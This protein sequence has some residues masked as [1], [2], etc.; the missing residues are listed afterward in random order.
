MI[1][2]EK[3]KAGEIRQSVNYKYF[4]PNLVNTDWTWSDAKINR[5][6]E[7]ASFQLGQLNSFAKLVPN[8][9]LFI[10]LHITKEAVVSSKIEGTQTHF[11]E[12]FLQKEN[13][14]VYISHA[15]S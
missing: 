8:I 15:F 3:Y 1:Q 12:A 6:I 14:K 11:D 4:L 2:I 7:D 5:L 9:D 13:N 10:H